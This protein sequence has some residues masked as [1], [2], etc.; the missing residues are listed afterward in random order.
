MSQP[1]DLAITNT[2]RSFAA[3]KSGT[4]VVIDG[5]YLEAVRFMTTANKEIDIK[6]TKVR[7]GDVASRFH[8]H[9]SKYVSAPTRS[10]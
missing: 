1:K 4:V 8:V 9:T 10:S 7:M 5:K 6:Q 3:S 2:V